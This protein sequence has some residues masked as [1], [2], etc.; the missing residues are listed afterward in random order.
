MP[1]SSGPSVPPNQTVFSPSTMA[2]TFSTILRRSF[3]VAGLGGV[4]LG[5]YLWGW[6]LLADV[7]EVIPEYETERGQRVTRAESAPSPLVSAL[8]DPRREEKAEIPTSADLSEDPDPAETA[9]DT[10]LEATREVTAIS[11]QPS[12]SS[13]G[14]PETPDL[15]LSQTEPNVF[16]A[17]TK[18]FPMDAQ[19]QKPQGSPRVPSAAEGLLVVN[20]YAEASSQRE[21]V[22]DPLAR[23]VIPLES[24][25]VRAQDFII[26]RRYAQALAVLSPLFVKPPKTWEPW[27]WVGTAQLGLGQWEE[28]QQSF[29]EG[30][31][32]DATVP[33]LWVH[34]ALVSQQQGRF[35]DALDALR[36]A[37]LLD[38]RLPEVQ[39]NLAYSLD[40]RGET[41][42][43]MEHYRTFLALTRGT[44]AYD[45]TRN[46]VRDRLIQLEKS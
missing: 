11:R 34:R 8:R 27:F 15:S 1:D 7:R 35:G 26:T 13:S 24:P 17:T 40:A 9:P 30:L 23:T 29:V 3:I 10:G 28:A 46:K 19:A 21:N 22:V 18:P 44:I 20:A 45:G 25:V 16:S 31:I 38:S 39:L 32:R 12:T 41:R 2:E 33:Q 4:G 14:V 36:Q 6:P 37:E 5:V 43:A 42:V